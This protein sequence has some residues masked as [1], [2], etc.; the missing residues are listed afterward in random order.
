MN[1]AGALS[2]SFSNYAN[3]SDRSGRTEYWTF[4][5]VFLVVSSIGMLIDNAIFGSNGVPWIELLIGAAALVPH[6]AVGV[7]RLH[8][9]GKSGWLILVALT[10]IGILL[11]LY[12][13][14]QPSEG[15]N[16]YGSGPLPIE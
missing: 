2:T 9:I 11:L 6:V 15:E 10:V 3:F 12:W 1:I 14:L 7:R 4:A 13:Y 8:D 5:I 16:A